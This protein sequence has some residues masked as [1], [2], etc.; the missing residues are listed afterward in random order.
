M[1]KRA[2]RISTDGKPWARYLRLSKAEAAEDRDKTPAERLEL[3]HAKLNGHLAELTAWMDEKGLPYS[4]EH[5]YRDAALSAWKPGVTRPEWEQMMTC[6]ERGQLGGIGIVA[7]DRFTRDVTTM[8]D[9]IKLADT[10]KVNIGG[11]RAGNLDLTT[12]EGIQQARGMAMQAANESLATS[13]R[14]KSTLARKMRD[15]KPMGGGRCFGFEI[16]G[17]IQVPAEVAIIR[18][19]ASRMLGG[20]PLQQLAADLNTRG[21]TTVRGGEWTGA[22]LGRMLG[23]HRYGGLVEHHG[24]IVGT[25][26]GEPV[27]DRDTYDAVQALLA[28]RRRGRRPTGRFPLT[29]LL[30]CSTCQRSMN[31]AIRNK[32][33]ADG[34]RQRE[35]R[36]PI[37]R[38]GCGRAILADE[39]ERIV[40][41]H[42]I[43]LLADP[44]NVAAIVAENAHLNEARAAQ[45]AKL[46][47]VEDRLTNLEVKWASGELIQA[48]YDRSKPVLDGQ[49]VKLLAGLDELA[50]AAAISSYDAEL[51]WAEMT[52]DEKRVVVR[53][54]RVRIEILPRRSGTRRFDP[55]RVTFPA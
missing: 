52:D 46:Q 9:L 23:A 27:L 24:E 17:E 2:T 4:D 53:R 44:D 20:E 41:E 14:I 55:E 11:P 22:N 8:E 42:M 21:L 28:S 5:I 18:E 19:I 38:G 7:V 29:G 34:T 6:A 26:K 1:G 3:T 15:G 49:R 43:G 10:F 30:I 32:P 25:M 13:F 37:Q 35:Y 50:P 48:A 54:Y 36:C 51:D 12:Y 45:L 40:G 39:V 47:A 16:G 33:L 31:G